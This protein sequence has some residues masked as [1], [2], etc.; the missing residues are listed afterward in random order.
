MATQV[1]LSA[2]RETLDRVERDAFVGTWTHPD[3][4]S[5]ADDILSK[6]N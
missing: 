1:R 3:H 2:S 5:A 4:W 6:S